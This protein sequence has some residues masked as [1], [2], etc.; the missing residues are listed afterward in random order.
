MQLSVIITRE[1]KYFVAL[2][3]DVDIASQGQ[4]T[5]ESLANLKEALNLYFEDKDAIRPQI[6]GRAMIKII[7][8]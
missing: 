2:A 3:P 8:V 5:E 4:T 7:E 6:Q 1:V